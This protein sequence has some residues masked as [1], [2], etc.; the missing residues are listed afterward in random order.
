MS[1]GHQLVTAAGCGDLENVQRLVAAGTSVNFSGS[2]G[3]T[4]LHAASIQGATH[5]VQFLL[6]SG[7]ELTHVVSH[8][9]G[10]QTRIADALALAMCYGHA[11]TAAALLEA[12][13]LG[14]CAQPP[15]TTMQTGGVRKVARDAISWTNKPDTELK[16][17]HQSAYKVAGRW[18]AQ[19]EHLRAYQRLAFLGGYHARIGDHAAHKCVGMDLVEMIVS[20]VDQISRQNAPH[21]RFLERF[22]RQGWAWQAT[23]VP[24]MP[25]E[26]HLGWTARAARSSAVPV[27]KHSIAAVAVVRKKN[28]TGSRR[29]RAKAKAKRQLQLSSEMADTNRGSARWATELRELREA[30]DCHHCPTTMIR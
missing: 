27:R 3:F 30:G 24:L 17:R 5:V 6:G 18:H 19:R 25:R 8:N 1:Q 14:V 9:P 21:G 13:Q 23:S 16:K 28:R 22:A 7:A 2:C 11:D 26:F 15:A 20:E 12:G 4:P 29:E 10:A